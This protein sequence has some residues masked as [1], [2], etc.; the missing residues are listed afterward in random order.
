LLQKSR[1][2]ASYAVLISGLLLLVPAGALTV[3]LPTQ[4]CPYCRE[5]QLLE[6]PSPFP[7]GILWVRQ[8]DLIPRTCDCCGGRGKIGRL[9]A[10]RRATV[11]S[12]KPPVFRAGELNVF[13]DIRRSRI[14]HLVADAGVS[15]SPAPLRGP[16]SRPDL[17]PVLAAAL[18]DE[19]GQV[20]ILAAH[21]LAEMRLEQ[22]LPPMIRTLR[23]SDDYMGGELCRGIRELAASPGLRAEA[24]AALAEVFQ[25]PSSSFD[26]RL[27][28]AVALMDLGELRNS[29][30]FVQ[31]LARYHYKSDLM[32]RAIVHYDRKDAIRMIIRTMAGTPPPYMGGLADALEKLTGEKFGPDPTAWYRW[33]EANK[34]RF[35]PQVE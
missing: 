21:G 20:R 30:F 24:V 15:A 34:D 27:C 22:A 3:L 35:P 7:Q 26:L 6:E 19:D 33:F 14:S 12:P 16:S 28:C 23:N 17:I 32:I 31:S 29:D 11:T 5:Q 1:S 8:A 9:K 10:W 2:T 18:Q 4:I 13:V 25:Q